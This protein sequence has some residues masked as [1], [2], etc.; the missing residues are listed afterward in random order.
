MHE[1]S[2]HLQEHYRQTFLAHGPTSKGVDW[3]DK[4]WAAILRQHKMLEIIREPIK[5][6]VS[7]LDV[8]CGY[9]ALVDLIERLELPIDYTGID[10]V[11]EM[12][13]SARAVHPDSCF[14]N[15]DIMEHSFGTFDYVVC[16]GILTQKLNA[17]T[18]TM[19]NYAQQLVR[20]AFSL[21]R[22]GIAFN[23]MSTFVNFQKENLYYRNP[24]EMLAWCMSEITPHA[25][26]DCAYELWYEYTVFL[27]KTIPNE[28]PA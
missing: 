11:G 2:R 20:K 28:A 6:R 1:I 4:E 14:I 17:S 9:G 5:D 21:C 10:I 27:Y 13:A 8:G 26:I 18:L 7:L 16:N 19:N 3:G 23:Q 25:R 12:I 24:A 22:R 15:G